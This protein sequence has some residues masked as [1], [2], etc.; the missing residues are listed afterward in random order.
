MKSNSISLEDELKAQEKRCKALQTGEWVSLVCSGVGTVVTFLTKEAVFAATPLTCS[1]FLNIL[2][3]SHQD[4]RIYDQSSLNLIEVQRQSASKIQGVRSEFL[5]MDFS[6]DNVDGMRRISDLEELST[7]VKQLESFLE[8]Q[9]GDY[10]SQGGAVNQEVSILR[11]HQLEM[12][13]AIENL[14]NQM[15]VTSEPLDQ[16]EILDHLDR[17]SA[18]VYELEQKTAVMASDGSSDHQEIN[19]FSSIGDSGDIS[20][21]VE[22]MQ[23]Q[24]MALEER[25]NFIATADP[26]YD[27]EM[28]QRTIESFVTP[29]QSQVSALETEVKS[30]QSQVNAAVEPAEN[31]SLVAAVN[32]N[33]AAL[34]VK[35]DDSLSQI[36]TDIGEFRMSLD[37]THGQMGE[38]QERMNSL[39]DL[40]NETASANRSEEIQRQIEIVHSPLREQ[41]NGI[42][43]KIAEFT[44]LQGQLDQVQSLAQQSVDQ[45]NPETIQARVTAATEPLMEK[46]SAVE[47]NLQTQAQSPDSSQD[48]M[49]KLHQFMEP[50]Q[51]HMVALEQRINQLSSEGDRTPLL[52]K[53]AELQGKIQVIETRFDSVPQPID[54]AEHL[55]QLNSTV[56]DMQTQ[57]DSISTKV[58]HDLNGMPQ[59]IEQKVQDKESILAELQALTF[60][61]K[62]SGQK[63]EA[64]SELDDLLSSLE[65]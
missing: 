34:Q 42:Q 29:L 36:A 31:N 48:I 61:E 2:S 54:H 9:G 62:I 55:N 39:Q 56:A 43:L 17:L 22:S 47:A 15:G 7:K 60:E 16:S 50:M 26:A 63:R 21:Q 51:S 52:Q 40:A 57:L 4:R 59:M 13:E 20:T 58:S 6:E 24:M 23:S 64:K 28:L 19:P 38:I 32:E 3:R 30:Q 8:I 11:N 37:Q 41:F 14:T 45:S 18:A 49:V 53:I 35:L 33:I 65:F 46:I 5:G 10:Y 44:Q 25:M 12:A 27:P 1:L